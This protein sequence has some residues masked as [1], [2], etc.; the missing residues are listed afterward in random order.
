M[1]SINL[2]AFRTLLIRERYDIH[3]LCH[4]AIDKCTHIYRKQACDNLGL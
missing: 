3:I 4:Q 2:K 1:S